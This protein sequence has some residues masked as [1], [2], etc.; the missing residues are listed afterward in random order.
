MRNDT[1]KDLDLLF[2][3]ALSDAEVKA[4]RGAWKAVS[5]RLDS[6]APAAAAA[7]RRSWLL[8]G[9]PAFAF[10][11][12]AVAVVLFVG[13]SEKT[14]IK[15]GE[16]ALAIVEQQPSGP[17]AVVEDEISPRASLGRDDN[18]NV[19]RDD[20]ENVGRDDNENV[21]REDNENVG[22]EDISNVIPSA[23]EESHPAVVKSPRAGFVP[24]EIQ[25]PEQ[26][27]VIPTVIPD[28]DL[29]SSDEISPR[30]SLGRDD[31]EN[32]GREDKE[33]VGREDNDNVIS[34]EVEKSQEESMKEWVDP[35]AEIYAEEAREAKKNSHKTALKLGGTLGGN[36]SHYGSKPSFSSG[37]PSAGI[38]ETS[39]SIYGIP[40]SFG[41]SARYHFTDKIA[42][43]AGANWSF[44][45]R[46]FQGKY[47]TEEGTFTHNMQYVGVPVSVSYD[48]VESKT[49]LFYCYAGGSAE[50]AIS[51][52]YFIYANSAAPILS[53]KVP[54][55]QYGLFGGIG[56]E[57]TVSEHLGLYVDPCVK[58]YFP[59]NQPKSIRTDKPLMFSFEAGL[60]FNL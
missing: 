9:A 13:H 33:N 14:I 57:F 1:N 43:S 3:E 50:K 29:E 47:K 42:V 23:V 40:V 24:K 44:L 16:E 46:T 28:S 4:P 7:P 19:G 26:I 12:A 38:Q 56:V 15:S 51:S 45:S 10:A 55:F 52:K 27:S 22:R 49:L 35:F 6:A 20:N 31:K 53:E 58:Y 17:V 37:L 41:L 30:A 18:E 36:D 54:S 59:G 2:K 48:V 8:W 25:T 11:A 39:L 21:G 60:R 34:S 32:V 5:A